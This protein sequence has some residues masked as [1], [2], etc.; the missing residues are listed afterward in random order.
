MLET[1]DNNSINGNTEWHQRYVRRKF[2]AWKLIK[3]TFNLRMGGGER[4]K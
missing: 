1:N 3:Y 4:M 2:I